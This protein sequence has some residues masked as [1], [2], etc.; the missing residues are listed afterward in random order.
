MTS[1]ERLLKE[2]D[3]VLPE[4]G[5]ILYK[6]LHNSPG[7]KYTSYKDIRQFSGYSFL[8]GHIVRV[9]SFAFL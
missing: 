4:D 6:S 2:E 7:I 5:Q 3:Q 9:F 8:T 1:E